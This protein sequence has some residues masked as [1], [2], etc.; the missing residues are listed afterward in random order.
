MRVLEKIARYVRHLVRSIGREHVQTGMHIKIVAQ[1]GHKNVPF[2][3]RIHVFQVHLHFHGPGHG[4]AFGV[5]DAHRIVVCVQGRQLAGNAAG[6]GHI[7]LAIVIGD[8]FRLIAHFHGAGRLVSIQVNAVNTAL[9]V[10]GIGDAKA[11]AQ[12]VT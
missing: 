4:K 12:E 7:Q 1:R 3:I 9:G 5:D 10:G 8:A 6:I 11:P 2:T